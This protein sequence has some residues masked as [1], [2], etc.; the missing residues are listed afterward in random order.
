M[1]DD[2]PNPLCR[3]PEEGLLRRSNR[4]V[5][6]YARSEDRTPYPTSDCA[7]LPAR[8]PTCL[9]SRVTAPLH[10]FR[11]NDQLPQSGD[12]AALPIRRSNQL[13]RSGLPAFRSEDRRPVRPRS[14]HLAVPKNDRPDSTYHPLGAPTG[15]RRFPVGSGCRSLLRLRFSAL[16]CEI[17]TD[18][19]AA[20][21]VA[22]SRS[23]SRPQITGGYPKTFDV[24]H[25]LVHNLLLELWRTEDGQR[26]AASRVPWSI[27]R[28]AS[29]STATSAPPMRCT[30]TPAS[31]RSPNRSLR[32]S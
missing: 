21:Q 4:L 24:V 23:F 12:H 8:R 3:P 25:R 30:E 19:R 2:R 5:R 7:A 13:P 11:R 28:F 14:N 10:R 18:R 1:R 27:A 17:S 26:D 6:P 20:P 29:S 15:A 16:R 32:G 31:C 22:N 9:L